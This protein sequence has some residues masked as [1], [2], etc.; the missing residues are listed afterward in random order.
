MSCDSAI[1]RSPTA[2]YRAVARQKRCPRLSQ[3]RRLQCVAYVGANM[4]PRVL[5]A[6]PCS[7]PVPVLGLSLCYKHSIRVEIEDDYLDFAS[8]K[9]RLKPFRASRVDREKAAA[10]TAGATCLA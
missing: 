10:S 6:P 9:S 5:D 3:R 7:F 1:G 2:E 8:S 4:A